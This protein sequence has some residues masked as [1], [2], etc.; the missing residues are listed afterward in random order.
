MAT[1]S[2]I[3]A[4]QVERVVP[5][6]QE[7]FE[8]STQITALIKRAADSH[9]VSGWTGND[10]NGHAL[11]VPIMQYVGGDYR[12]FNYDGGDMGGGS[13]AKMAY[14]HYGYFPATYNIELTQLQREATASKE[15]AVVNIFN[16]HLKRAIKEAQAYDESS[17]FQDSTGVLATGAGTGTPTS[18]NPTINLEANFGPQRLRLGQIVDVYSSGLDTNRTSSAAV[19]VTKIDWTNKTA[20]ITGTV[21]GVANTDRICFAGMSATLTAGS[22][23]NGLYTFNSSATSG[24]T[25]GLDRSV[26]TEIQTPNVAAGSSAL[27][28]AHVLLLS[29]QIIQRRDEN[30]LASMVGVCHMAQRAACFFT[31]ISVSEWHRGTSDK[32]IDI[33]PANIS[34]STTFPMAGIKHYISKKADRSR[35]D[36]FIAKNYGRALLHDLKFHDVGKGPIFETRAAT[37]NNVAAGMRMHMVSTDQIY[38]V[39][40]GAAGFI[41][42]LSLPSGY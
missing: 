5:K 29:D 11:R 12:T 15:Q 30:A 9:K 27:V 25:G 8:T 6:L 32:M 35:V 24:T 21:T 3:V 20:S 18:P 16:F 13:S 38:S 34:E 28:P 37:T 7:W 2:D 36:W 40:P 42:G 4:A 39:D 1:N 22:W 23:K 14:M 31:G 33:V 10:G 41:S 26:Y 17:F 19:R